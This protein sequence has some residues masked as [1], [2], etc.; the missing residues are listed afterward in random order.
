MPATVSVG[1]NSDY[2][3]QD[4]GGIAKLL[5]VWNNIYSRWFF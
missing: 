5:K 1:Q 4:I 3:E 2:Q